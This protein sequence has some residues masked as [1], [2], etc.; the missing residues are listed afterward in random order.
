MNIGDRIEMKGFVTSEKFL[1]HQTLPEI[2]RR[3]GFQEG[4][5]AEGAIF[6]VAERIPQKGEFETRGY[7]Q[8]AGHKH[9]PLEGYNK[10][11][12]QT[13]AQEAMSEDRLI[14]VVPRK[15]HNPNIH[16]DIQYPPG[17][18]VPQ[19]EVTS[20]IPFK[21][22]SIVEEGGKYVGRQIHNNEAPN[23]N[24]SN[25]NT[26]KMDNNNDN[27]PRISKFMKAQDPKSE[28]VELNPEFDKQRKE[29]FDRQWSEKTKLTNDQVAEIKGAGGQTPEMAAKFRDQQKALDTKH[30]TEIKEFDKKEQAETKSKIQQQANTEQQ[31]SG[32]TSKNQQSQSEVKT[33][34]TQSQNDGQKR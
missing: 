24:S 5:L 16:D 10:D 2:E 28:R 13:K 27:D 20:K 3:L 23:Q 6:L 9:V 17:S 25:P 7:S 4:R 30:E 21:V 19:W 26:N 18:G 12:L 22:E 11:V 29:M 8:V 31:R 15:T 34:N 1:L 33:T 32:G 14:K